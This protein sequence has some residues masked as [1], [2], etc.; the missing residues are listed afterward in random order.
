MT[1]SSAN[2]V[3]KDCSRAYRYGA[4]LVTFYSP[5]WW[6][7]DSFQ[8]LEAFGQREPTAMWVRIFDALQDAEITDIELAFAP[9]NWT[10][11]E[12]AFGSREGFARELAIRGMALTGGF[13][14]EQEWYPGQSTRQL[15]DEIER[16]AMFLQAVGAPYVVLGLP[17]RRRLDLAEDSAEGESLLVE[18]SEVVQEIAD[19]IRPTGVSI[20]VHTEA[21]S[22]I[23]SNYSIDRLVTMT[24]PRNVN[25]CLDASHLVLAGED[26]VKTVLAHA[27]RVVLAH[28]K[29]ASAANEAN[30]ALQE[31][32]TM[33]DL[34][35]KNFRR[36]GDG[37]VDWHKWAAA[38]ETTPGAGTRII[39]IDASDD[40]VG[41]LRHARG[42]IE[43]ISPSLFD[44]VGP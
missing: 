17:I 38:L 23:G 14:L 4:E 43:G 1:N 8:E 18:T 25:V 39:E 20:A 33:H 30:P 44:S 9:A 11:A 7:F 27:D 24:D 16:L 42:I 12:R 22:I 29:D 28:W 10:S 40:P 3:P 13:H 5:R 19:R 36:L 6:G 34:H 26:P 35:L 32:M 41:D 31:G 2:N 37:I 21:H 15:S